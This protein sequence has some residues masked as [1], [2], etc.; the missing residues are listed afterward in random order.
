M[1]RLPADFSRCVGVPDHPKCQDC[2]RRQQIGLD[3]PKRWYPMM[4][5]PINRET[6]ICEYFIQL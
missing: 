6:G 2:A 3:D 1:R 4:G 5:P